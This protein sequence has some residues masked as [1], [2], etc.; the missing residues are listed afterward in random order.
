MLP[1]IGGFAVKMHKAAKVAELLGVEALAASLTQVIISADAKNDWCTVN[2]R[3]SGS[4]IPVARLG[5][6]RWK[7]FLETGTYVFNVDLVGMAGHTINISFSGATASDSTALTLPGLPGTA[8]SDNRDIA[9][10]VA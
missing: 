2:V 8:S 1:E 7:Y 6:T 10:A 4:P 5:G 9:F 3:K